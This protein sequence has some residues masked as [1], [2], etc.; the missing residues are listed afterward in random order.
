M[1]QMLPIAR[2]VDLVIEQGANQRPLTPGPCM[3]DVVVRAWPAESLTRSTRSTGS[4]GPL[5]GRW[6]ATRACDEEV[7]AAT[8]TWSAST[9]AARTS[10]RLVVVPWNPA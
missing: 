6:W 2:R 9:R 10:E 3:Q 1:A 5:P 7:A 4:T 8:T